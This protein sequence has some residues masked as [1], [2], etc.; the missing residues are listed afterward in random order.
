M[1]TSMSWSVCRNYT[2]NPSSPMGI[3]SEMCLGEHGGYKPVRAQAK[4]TWLEAPHGYGEGNCRERKASL[5]PLCDHKEQHS[6]SGANLLM[7]TT[8]GSVLT[9]VLVQTD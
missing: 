1:L 7:E 4:S 2:P 3:M 5:C 6:H 9:A 8:Y